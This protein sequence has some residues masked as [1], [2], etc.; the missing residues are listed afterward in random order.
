MYDGILIYPLLTTALFYLG[1]RAKLTAPI[2]R[3]LPGELNEVLAC[4]ACSGAWYGMAC[5]VFGFFTR[6]PF[7]GASAWWTLPVIALASM[8][9]TPMLAALQEAS[10]YRLWS[11]PAQDQQPNP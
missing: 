9:W 8:I 4:P 10:I 2:T 7:L 1:A 6:T 5:A 11:E 3:H